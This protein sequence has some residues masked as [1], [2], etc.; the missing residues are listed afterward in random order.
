MWYCVPFLAFTSPTRM[1]FI[2]ANKNF[3]QS[4]APDCLRLK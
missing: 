2:I 1:S 4:V 3:V